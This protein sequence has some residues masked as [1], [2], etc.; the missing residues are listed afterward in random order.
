MTRWLKIYEKG[1]MY[2]CYVSTY[3]RGIMAFYMVGKNEWVLWMVWKNGFNAWHALPLNIPVNGI[4]EWYKIE[5]WMIYEWFMK[6]LY[7]NCLWLK[8]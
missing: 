5:L 4:Y 8:V 3:P 6:G 1:F 7:E 2:I